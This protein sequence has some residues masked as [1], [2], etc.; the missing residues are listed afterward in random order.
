MFGNQLIENDSEYSWKGDI[1]VFVCTALLMQDALTVGR[2]VA[3]LLLSMPVITH[4]C[5][6]DRESSLKK[7]S[8]NC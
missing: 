6:F 2:T 5:R 1:S 3:N 8:D 4:Q 7:T